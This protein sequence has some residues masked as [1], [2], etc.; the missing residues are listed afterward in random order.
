MV[1]VEASIGT[2]IP[3]ALYISR[4]GRLSSSKAFKRSR[5]VSFHDEDDDDDDDEN[6]V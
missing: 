2:R 6:S 3:S 4:I 1:E 5:I